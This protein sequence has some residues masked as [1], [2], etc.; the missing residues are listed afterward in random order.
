[1]KGYL[2]YCYCKQNLEKFEKLDEKTDP[3]FQEGTYSECHNDIRERIQLGDYLFLRTNWRQE[4]YIIGYYE[5]SEKHEGEFGKILIAKNRVC[6]DFNLYIDQELLAFLR[7]GLKIELK[8]E[9]MSWA[10]YVNYTLGHRK[11]IILNEEK[12]N[13]LLS[14]IKQNGW[15]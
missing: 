3:N 2:T 4:P 1:M 12:T 10:Q 6:I 14:K 15:V 8:P 9:E 7:P 11:Y 5:I 13:S